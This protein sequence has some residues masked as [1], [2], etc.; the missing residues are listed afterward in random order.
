M[1]KIMIIV[2]MTMCFASNVMAQ[3]RVISQ[4]LTLSKPNDLAKLEI[5]LLN[6]SIIVEGSNRK[7][8]EVTASINSLKKQVNSVIEKGLKRIENNSVRLAIEE[9]NNQVSI[10]SNSKNQRVELVVKVPTR[11]ALD[12]KLNKGATIK[13]TNIH[14]AIEVMSAQASIIA[15]GIN[16]PIIAESGGKSIQVIF[17]QFN[18]KKSSSITAH[19]G[20][21]DVSLPKNS[22][23]SVEV[24]SYQGNIYSDIN[25]KFKAIDNIEKNKSQDNQQIIVAGSMV[26]S[27]NGGSQKLMLTTLKGDIYVRE[28]K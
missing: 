18:D 1:K 21:V 24:K 5:L 23:V 2:F 19:K 4:T 25:A 8:V 10:Q 9:N 6:G 14:D 26:A 12:L 3:E 13:I 11:T 22:K 17:N 28:H 16:G 27:L 7:T 15:T 20:N